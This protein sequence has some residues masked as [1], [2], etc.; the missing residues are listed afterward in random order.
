MAV[1]ALEVIAMKGLLNNFRDV[2]T[3]SSM[4]GPVIVL[5]M[6]VG[7]V[8]NAVLHYGPKLLPER[9]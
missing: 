6:M 4:V 2:V 9:G 5:L 7:E 3:A 1:V 8:A